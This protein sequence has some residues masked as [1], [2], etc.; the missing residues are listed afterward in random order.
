MRT[1]N[2]RRGLWPRDLADEQGPAEELFLYK[3]HLRHCVEKTGL[4]S[5]QTVAA[6]G[7]LCARWRTWDAR[8]ER[9]KTRGKKV[10]CQTRPKAERTP[11]WRLGVASCAFRD[12]MREISMHLRCL[13][14]C[15]GGPIT[16]A[17]TAL[18]M[19]LCSGL[20]LFRGG[21]QSDELCLH[22]WAQSSAV[23]NGAI[24]G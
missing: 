16:L 22:G 13:C 12:M 11:R 3:C 24:L 18:P 5:P 20:V 10:L 14:A 15:S 17:G 9:E 8:R 2:A 6:I 23:A 21:S 7:S 1:S 19:Q 4:S